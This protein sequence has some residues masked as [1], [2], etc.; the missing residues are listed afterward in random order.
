MTLDVTIGLRGLL[1]VSFFW[2]ECVR[3]VLLLSMLLEMPAT[4][5]VPGRRKDPPPPYQ[6][7]G[8]MCLGH[9]PKMAGSGYGD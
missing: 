9:H 5:H 4:Y 8:P 1:K 2:G 6:T 7:R 3:R